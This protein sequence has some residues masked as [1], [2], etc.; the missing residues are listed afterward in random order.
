MAQKGEEKGEL[1]SQTNKWR[2]PRMTDDS[3]IYIVL[4][5]RNLNK[6]GE[7]SSNLKSSRNRL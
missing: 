1:G 2:R 5:N 4:C 6:N 3:R 7:G